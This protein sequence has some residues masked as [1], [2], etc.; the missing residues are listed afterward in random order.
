MLIRLWYILQTWS[1]I[2]WIPFWGRRQLR[3]LPRIKSE[4]NIGII[5]PV[6]KSLQIC[7]NW[8]IIS[9]LFFADQLNLITIAKKVMFWNGAA[10]P[11]LL[12]KSTLLVVL[13]NSGPMLIS[14]KSKSLLESRLESSQWS[15]L[16]LKSCYCP[17]PN[18]KCSKFNKTLNLLMSKWLRSQFLKKYLEK[19]LFG[20]TTTLNKMPFTLTC[21]SK[22]SISKILT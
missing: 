21:L 3:F 4:I 17:V 7:W 5:R 1:V 22:I 10:L 16:N 18:S 19:L 15:K 9:E 13:F 12:N 2:S 6:K 20:L 14:L 8:T 11:P